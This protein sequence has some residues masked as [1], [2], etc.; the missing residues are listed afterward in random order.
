MSRYVPDEGDIVWMQFS[1]TVGREQSGRRPAVV[2]TKAEY[3]R[4][5]GLMFCTP[6]TS[7]VK[8]Y[9]FEVAV[10]GGVALVDHSRSIDWEGRGISRKGAA[11]AAELESI[12]T[13]LRSL[14]G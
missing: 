11:S 2:L 10:S 12:R 14:I 5:S 4:R 13:K 6:M 8:G 1:P 3:N 7:R 9:P